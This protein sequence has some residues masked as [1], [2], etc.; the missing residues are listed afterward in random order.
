VK[1]IQNY[2]LTLNLVKE[3]FIDNDKKHIDLRSRAIYDDKK[4]SKKS[5][6]IL[7]DNASGT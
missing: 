5:L 2:T 7:E 3:K 1:V 6:H 4:N